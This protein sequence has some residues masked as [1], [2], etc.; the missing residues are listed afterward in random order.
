VYDRTEKTEQGL[1]TMTG[2]DANGARA[3]AG[4]DEDGQGPNAANL[5]AEALTNQAAADRLIATNVAAVS[6]VVASRQTGWNG[7]TPE[8]QREREDERLSRKRREEEIAEAEYE[9]VMADVRERAGRLIVQFE[10]ERR[11]TLQKLAEVQARPV[12]LQDGRVVR[13]GPNGEPLDAATDTPLQGADK[14]EAQRQQKE[15]EEEEKKH[16][17][18]IAQIDEAEEHARKAQDFAGQDGKNL[19]QDGKKQRETEAREEQAKA[20]A[21]ANAASTLSDDDTL[22]VFGLGAAPANARTTSFAATLDPKDTLAANLQDHF[23]GAVQPS[24]I[25]ASPPATAPAVDSG[26][27]T[28]VTKSQFS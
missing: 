8:Q 6:G 24:S 14:T 27:N 20:E 11:E 3:P 17:D 15:K 7:L 21:L 5:A 18:R 13:F 25:P 19:K 16:I 2:N 23:T 12:I 4:A 9:A 28:S 1:R 22:S 10:K 26:A